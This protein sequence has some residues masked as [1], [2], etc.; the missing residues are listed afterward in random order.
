M[1]RWPAG[2]PQSAFASTW[3]DVDRLAGGVSISGSRAGPRVT[4][5][6]RRPSVYRSVPDVREAVETYPASRRG[7][8]VA[9]A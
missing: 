8:F 3:R 1:Y 5:S 2:R 6:V 4:G 9:D 7:E